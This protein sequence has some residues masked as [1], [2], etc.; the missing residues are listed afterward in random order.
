MI[1]NR[2]RD[3]AN[4]HIRSMQHGFLPSLGENFLALLYRSIDES[5]HGILI[6]HYEE[7]SLLGFV[8]GTTSMRSI[9]RSIFRSP[10]KLLN[11]LFPVLFSYSKLVKIFEI[12][13]HTKSNRRQSLPDAELLSISVEANAKGSGVASSLYKQLIREFETRRVK[14]F[15]IVVGQQLDRAN[16]FYKKMGATNED[17]ISVHRSSHSLI[18]IQKIDRG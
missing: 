6:T 2:Y 17:F 1:E 18:Y 13:R 4:L 12:F 7:G 14:E 3:V 10:W 9:Y 15:V 8:S 5:D 11:S 16:A